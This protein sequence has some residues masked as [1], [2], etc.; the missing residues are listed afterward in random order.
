[1]NKDLTLFFEELRKLATAR[2]GIYLGAH[3]NALIE[4]RMVRLKSKLNFDGSLEELLDEIK[5]DRF[6]KE[7]VS[8][9]TTNQTSFFREAAQFE[10][11]LNEFLPSVSSNSN[12]I[13]VLCAGCSS[14]EE[15]YT[16]AICYDIFKN[17][18]N[19]A[20]PLK[21][22]AV[23]I[24]EERLKAAREGVYAYP[25]K[26]P[27]PFFVKESAYFDIYEENGIK[28]MRVK[29]LLKGLISFEKHNLCEQK[30]GFKNSFYDAVFCRNTLIYF[31]KPMQETI[32]KKLLLSLKNG[33]MIYLGHSENPLSHIDKLQKKGHNIYI[34][35]PRDEI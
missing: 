26:T 25:H 12:Q 35:K 17:S 21:V 23:D 20:A 31:D 11:F 19:N 13:S 14:G 16:M 15:A 27:F 5:K 8:A 29:E 18:T 1:L 2:L 6:T 4:N 24:D 33:G 32:L 22:T 28:K 9:F 10:Y 30:E 34:K 7:F 3:K